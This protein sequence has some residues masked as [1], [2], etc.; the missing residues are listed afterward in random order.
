VVEEGF[1]RRGEL[2]WWCSYSLLIWLQ[3]D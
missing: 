3:Y 1:R 2:S